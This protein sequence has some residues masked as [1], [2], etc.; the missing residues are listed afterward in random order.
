MAAVGL[1][2]VGFAAVES[3]VV[4]SHYWLDISRTKEVERGKSLEDVYN[5]Y[6]NLFITNDNWSV[7][8]GGVPC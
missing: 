1:A 2:A 7:G 3:A 4:Y 8:G 6:I 5:M